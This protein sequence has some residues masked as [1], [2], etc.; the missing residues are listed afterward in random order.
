MKKR[1]IIVCMFLALFQFSLVNAS[2]KISVKDFF[3]YPDIISLKLSPSGKY[4]AAKIKSNNKATLAILERKTLKLVYVFHFGDKKREEIGNYGWL[5]NSRIWTT[6]VYKA[7]P[8]GKQRPTGQLY[9]G[10]VDGTKKIQLLPEKASRTRSGS[11]RARRFSFVDILEEDPKYILISKSSGRYSEVF[12]LNVYSGRVRKIA[13][14]PGPFSSFLTDNDGKLKFAVSHVQKTL[15]NELYFRENDEWQLI[16]SRQDTA[17]GFSP[18]AFTPNNQQVY[19]LE[20]NGKKQAIHL[21]DLKSKT[22]TLVKKIE[23]D[24]D[25]T[26]YLWTDR[27][28]K[29]IGYVQEPGAPKSTFFDTSL[30]AVKEIQQL[31]SLFTDQHLVMVNQTRDEKLVLLA[32]YSDKNPGSYY[33]FDRNK[34]SISPVLNLRDKINRKLMAERKPISFTA[35]DGLEIRGFLT[36]PNDKKKNLPFVLLV[37]GGPYGPSDRWGFDL[38]S[39]FLANRGYAVLQVNYRGSGGRGKDFQYKHYQEVGKE[40]QDDLTDATLWAVKEGIADRQ[41]LCIY[42]GSYGGYAALMGVVKEPDLYKCAIGY[43]GVYDIAIQTKDSDTAEFEYGRRFLKEAWNAYDDDFVKERS[44]IYHLAKLKAA[45]FLVHGKDDPRT[46]FTQ[47]EALSKAL[48][49]MNY[50]YKSLVKPYELHGFADQK[51]VYELYT[52]MERFL[53]KQLKN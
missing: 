12:K 53:A 38:E 17:G 11:R 28:T 49:K 22:L 52:E 45:I 48:D 37:H 36:L 2:Q 27:S 50:P 15:T 40:M 8:L 13:R 26:G 51:N 3:T 4:F 21:Y 30:P 47:Y 25:I 19:I 6:K 31:E 32:T 9:A 46:P 29:L 24:A 18:I 5:N 34:N 16:D 14:S 1:Y 33:L 35:R 20:S 39:Q 42:G 43:A 7:G 41:R 10:N 23:G 44:P